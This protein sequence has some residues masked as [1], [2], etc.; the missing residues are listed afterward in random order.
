M[1]PRHSR[2]LASA[3]LVRLADEH[4]IFNTS[5]GRECIAIPRKRGGQPGNIN[6]VVTGAYAAIHEDLLSPEEKAIYDGI[7]NQH[8]RYESLLKH[9]AIMRIRELRMM[10]DI[11][12]IRAGEKMLT[13]RT[14]SQ[15]EPTGQ[16]S[17]EGREVTKVVRI[18]QE[19][20]NRLDMLLR[21]EDSL[22]RIQTEIRRTED[23]LRQVGEGE[24]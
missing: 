10:K 5:R 8:T 12:D 24:R 13:R 4:A 19:Q 11:A 18:T 21:F 15:V 2:L 6:A 20:E 9:L 17:A 7:I 23:S 22:T 16:R 14:V 1:T 3:S